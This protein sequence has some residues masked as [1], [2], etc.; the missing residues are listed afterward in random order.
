MTSWDERYGAADYYYG[1]EANEFLR[2]NCSKI[3]RGGD[4]LCLAE[5]EGRNAVF[6]A[7]QGFRPVAVDQSAVGLAKAERLAAARDVQIH[8]VLANLDAYQIEPM[9]WDGIVSIW[10]HLPAPLRAKVHHGVVTGLK[11]GGVFLLEAYTP[12]QLAYGT[13]GPRSVDLLPTLEQLRE[14]LKGLE[15]VHA[16]ERERTVHEGG[17]HHGLS[18]VVQVVACRRR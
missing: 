5:G 15:F 6:L 18:A 12:A 16:L 9:R 4:V 2:E 3:R 7:Q 14:E 8:T 13:G 1:T 11:V 10:C 17:G